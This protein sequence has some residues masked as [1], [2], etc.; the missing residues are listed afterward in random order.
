MAY[1]AADHDAVRPRSLEI[2]RCGD[3]FRG[4]QIPSPSREKIAHLCMVEGW[5][6]HARGGSTT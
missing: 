5:E 6:Q 1:I 3:E 4:N 2:L